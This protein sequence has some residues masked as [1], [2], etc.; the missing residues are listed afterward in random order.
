LRHGEAGILQERRRECAMS[1]RET[2]LGESKTG[3][4]NV[5]GQTLASQAEVSIHLTDAHP[6]DEL[7]Y[8]AEDS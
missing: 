8:S 1:E 2:E 7:S 6:D 5:C 3:I 4:C